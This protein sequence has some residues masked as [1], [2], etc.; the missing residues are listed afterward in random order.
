MPWLVGWLVSFSLLLFSSLPLLLLS[1]SP[2]PSL[3]YQK[4][5]MR[6]WIILF[7]CLPYTCCVGTGRVY[8]KKK[9]QPSVKLTWGVRSLQDNTHSL[10]GWRWEL[11]L[12]PSLRQHLQ[13][14]QMRLPELLCCWILTSQLAIV[15]HCFW[16]SY[17]M[18]KRSSALAMHKKPVLY[19][20]VCTC[21]NSFY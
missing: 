17:S 15:V 18:Y 5:T 12:R 11:L 19:D 4:T 3:S 14:Y 1:F 16:L 7:N 13:L 9:Q 10:S 2:S 21:K 6:C 8:V 20:H